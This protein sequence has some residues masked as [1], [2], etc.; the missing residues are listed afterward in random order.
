MHSFRFIC[1][2]ILQNAIAYVYMHIMYVCVYMWLCVCMSIPMCAYIHMPRLYRNSEDNLRHQSSDSTCFMTVCCCLFLCISKNLAH[3]L[4]RIL[5]SPSL[6][7]SLG[8]H[9]GNRCPLTV[10]G[11]I[12]VLWIW[13]IKI[14]L[15]V[16]F[17]YF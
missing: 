13:T 17:P 6:I 3:E 9:W 4:P 1:F 11:F 16:T 10:S 12:L 7:S 15:M 5:P 14:L 2:W 8:I